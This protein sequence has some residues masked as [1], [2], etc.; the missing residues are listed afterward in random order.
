MGAVSE[1]RGRYTRSTSG[2]VGALVVTVLVILGFVVFRALNRSDLEVGPE[3][4]DYLSQVRFVQEEWADV[5]YP[6]RLPAGWYATRVSVSSEPPPELAL[7]ML[8]GDDDYVGFVE[9]PATPADLLTEYVDAHPD[10]GARVRV[11]GS[12]VQT[13]SSWTDPGGDTALATTRGRETLLVFGTVS[14]ADLEELAGSLT[15]APVAG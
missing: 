11:G 9:S 15:V 14:Q 8:T 2:M 6:A 13:W 1:Q 4:V 7:S 12:V 10:A 5:V 3:R